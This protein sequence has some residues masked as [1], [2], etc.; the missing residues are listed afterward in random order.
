M[1]EIRCV[2]DYDFSFQESKKRS[3]CRSVFRSIYCRCS[4]RQPII[5]LTAI[6]SAMMIKIS[7]NENKQSS[8]SIVLRDGKGIYLMYEIVDY[9]NGKY[10][11]KLK[12]ET[13]SFEE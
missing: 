7:D 8:N 12:S 5:Q 6:P 3:V 9:E 4:F 11:I 1:Y 2:S 13:E 10:T